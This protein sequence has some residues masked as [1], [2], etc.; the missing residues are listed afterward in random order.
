MEKSMAP[1]RAIYAGIA[2]VFAVLLG[3]YLMYQIP[4]VVL[5]FLLTVLLSIIL[6]GPVNYLARRGV[7]RA[8]A[9]LALIGA[10]VLALWIFGLAF[11]R[12][13]QEQSRELARNFPTLLQEAQVFVYR[14]L[15]PFGLGAMDLERSS[16]D[17]G[18]DYLWG[19][20][21]DSTVSVLADAGLIVASSVSLALVA[22]VAA[23][24][25]VIQP[26]PWINGFVSLFP[27]GWR[28][29]S[30]E[31]LKLIYHTTQMWFLGQ[32]ASMT[33]I[34]V[35]SALALYAI[36]IPF[37]LLLGVFSGLISFVPY[38]GPIVSA[39]PPVLLALSED[40]IKAVWVVLAYIVIQQIEGSLLQPVVMSQ[41]VN[42]HPTLVV[43]AILVMG[44]L[45]G[46]VGVLLAIPLAAALQV[47]VRELWVER[48]NRIGTDRYALPQEPKKR[49][50][51]SPLR[52]ALK[53]ALRT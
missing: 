5:T 7:P 4:Q 41:T 10:F 28:E 19:N 17:V 48:M 3:G 20:G 15:R 2:L 45:F 40:P 18:R 53:K 33:V 27:A 47:L 24:Y 1:G 37:A 46:F 52:K 50:P 22:L 34:G 21:V 39:V 16:L 51:L 11:V 29:R 36:G 8:W 35:L 30:R 32:L 26:D 13:I 23:I 49:E 43:F 25:L 42:L 14:L 44:T 6:S 9:V 38:A 31:M 12:L